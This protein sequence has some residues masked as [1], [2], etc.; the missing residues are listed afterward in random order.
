[1]KI[2]KINGFCISLI[3]IIILVPTTLSEEMTDTQLEINDVRSILGAVETDV[4]NIGDSTAEDI[5]ISI[6]VYGGILNKIDIQHDCSGCSQCG[7]TLAA[8]SIKTENT[9]EAGFIIGFGNVEITITA[10]ATNANEVSKIFHGLVIGPFIIIKHTTFK[11]IDGYQTIKGYINDDTQLAKLVKTSGFKL[12]I[13]NAQSMMNLRMYER[14]GDIWEGWSKNVFLGM[15]Q[16][17]KIKS[18]LLQFLLLLALVF[19][20]F[21]LLVFPSL[22][23]IILILKD[24]ITQSFTWQYFFLFVV[25]TWIVSIVSIVLVQI[26]FKIGKARY[27]PLTNLI[28]GIIFMGIYLNSAL[29]TLSGKEVTW[30]GRKYSS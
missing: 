16:N 4:K 13:A 9:L 25:I 19:I 17:R 2:T 12:G 18:K 26:L 21:D 1:M 11:K 8:G 15:V 5:S 3:F 22:I 28:G 24:L 10:S 27:T 20:M 23:L 29:K 6:Y 14:F 30:K 7:T